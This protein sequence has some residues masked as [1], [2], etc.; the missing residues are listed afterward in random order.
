MISLTQSSYVSSSSSHRH[1]WLLFS[2]PL[3]SEGCDVV[4]D[5]TLP[6]LAVRYDLCNHTEHSQFFAI[7]P[8]SSTSFITSSSPS[9]IFLTALIR[10]MLV[11]L[12]PV[13]PSKRPRVLFYWHPL[14]RE[15]NPTK[16]LLSTETNPDRVFSTSNFTEKEANATRIN[17]WPH[18]PRLVTSSLL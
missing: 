18:L 2:P 4:S 5:S 8:Y 7:S 16:S 12:L 15:S 9:W 1:L 10:L 13:C 3:P 17:R 14:G 11:H 6:L